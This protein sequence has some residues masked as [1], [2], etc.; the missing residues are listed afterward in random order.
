M[1]QTTMPVLIMR[2]KL[3]S[4]V[5]VIPKGPTR[6]FSLISAASAKSSQAALSG[7]G[8]ISWTLSCVMDSGP[9]RL[10]LESDCCSI[11]LLRVP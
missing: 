3:S 10:R 6:F 9:V 1:E 7:P 8:V 2:W 11:R 5:R 4:G